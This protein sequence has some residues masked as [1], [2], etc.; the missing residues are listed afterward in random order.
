MLVVGF[1]IGVWKLKAIFH[2]LCPDI[3]VPEVILKSEG[4]KTLLDI[5]PPRDV[6]ER[7]IL[8]H[9]RNHLF[10]VVLVDGL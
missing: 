10:I 9:K 6:I 2:H 1:I 4:S 8:N 7:L 5:L 3:E